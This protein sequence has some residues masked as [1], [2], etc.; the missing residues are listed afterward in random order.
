MVDLVV[1]CD[2]ATA[3]LEGPACL[4]LRAR[5]QG[6][7]LPLT[8]DAALELDVKTLLAE[9]TGPGDPAPLGDLSSTPGKPPHNPPAPAQPLTSSSW[10]PSWRPAFSACEPGLTEWMKLPRALPPSRV[11]W[12]GRPS[13][14]SVARCTASPGPRA[15]AADVTDGRKGLGGGGAAVRQ[16]VPKALVVLRPA[17]P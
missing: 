16:A 9:L 15:C 10:W 3:P 8:P 17:S 11:S 2:R 5:V 12:E 14:L 7:I 13:P 4:L 6:D 1:Q